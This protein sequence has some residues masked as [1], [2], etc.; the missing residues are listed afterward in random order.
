[1]GHPVTDQE[2]ADQLRAAGWHL[3]APGELYLHHVDHEG[4]R[5]RV[6]PRALHDVLCT[7]RVAT[8]QGTT[9]EVL[10]CAGCGFC[11]PQLSDTRPDQAG[12]A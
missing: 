2:A 12:G 10:G 4:V 7:W 8:P 3:F 6:I 5:M 9:P 11:Y 1:V